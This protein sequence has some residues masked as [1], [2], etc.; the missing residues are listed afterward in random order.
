MHQLKLKNKA[1]H[2]RSR[3]HSVK[4]IAKKLSIAQSTSSL[5]VRN[6]KLNKTAQERL[7]R[8]RLLSYY[9][10]SLKWQGKRAKEESM[11]LAAA[12]KTVDGIKNSI[13]HIRL[14]CALL[15][16]CEG[17]KGYLESV[18]FVNS[19]PF[20]IDVFLKLFRRAFRL[21]EDKFRV[22]MHLHSYHNEEK[23][24]IF[25]S[26]LTKIPKDKFNKTFL[27]SNTRKRIR[28]NY[29]G[30]VM[31]YYHDRKVARELRAIY[32]AFSRKMGA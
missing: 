30:C 19:D 27:K 6:I 11:Y 1:F 28:E 5:W 9:R 8:R 14:Y 26:S 18:K 31:I 16:W 15:Y 23:Q 17:G 7:K 12:T 13:N 10:A 4:E 21:D 3:G 20:L 29:P 24:K 25:W 2:L 32:K 22:L